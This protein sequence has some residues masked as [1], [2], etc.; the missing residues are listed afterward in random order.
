MN[1]GWTDVKLYKS[2]LNPYFFCLWIFV[3]FF[4]TFRLRFDSFH[5]DPQ[6]RGC[7]I[8]YFMF[9]FSTFFISFLHRI[10]IKIE[11]NLN[12]RKKKQ[13]KRRRVYSYI[14]SNHFPIHF[15]FNQTNFSFLFSAFRFL[16]TLMMSTLSMCVMYCESIEIR[17]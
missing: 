7:N 16:F 4:L 2:I 14:L 13:K 17:R 3:F 5:T 15:S 8:A 9:Y 6:Y 10:S 1:M 12:K 11:K